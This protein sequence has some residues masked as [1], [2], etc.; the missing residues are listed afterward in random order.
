[1][2]LSVGFITQSLDYL[3]D[4]ELREL[5]VLVVLGD[6]PLEVVER[7]C[8]GVNSLT[9]AGVG[10][11]A[12]FSCHVL[13]VALLRAFFTARCGPGVVSETVVRGGWD[14]WGDLMGFGGGDVAH[15][16]LYVVNTGTF[17]VDLL[18]GFGGGVADR[19]VVRYGMTF[20]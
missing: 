3:D 8:D 10:F 19:G 2:V 6:G 9:F 1:M 11:D 20:A 18:A 14:G 5:A 13:V 12:A 4:R 16:H 17:A 7:S 15:E